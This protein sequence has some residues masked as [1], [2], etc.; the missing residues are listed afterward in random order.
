M[1]GLKSVA[2]PPSRICYSRADIQALETN[3]TDKNE[4]QNWGD[5]MN[6]PEHEQTYEAFLSYTKWVSI[7]IIAI[8]VFLLLFVYD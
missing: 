8:L 1:Q 2:C 6:R 3:M 4:S 7:G 5:E